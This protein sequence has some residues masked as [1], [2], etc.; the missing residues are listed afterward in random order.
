MMR[1]LKKP[2]TREFLSGEIEPRVAAIGSVLKDARRDLGSPVHCDR[3]RQTDQPNA[4]QTAPVASSGRTF[5]GD[6]PDQGERL[7]GCSP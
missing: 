1:G 6:D 4:A 7:D 2:P 3:C 5:A